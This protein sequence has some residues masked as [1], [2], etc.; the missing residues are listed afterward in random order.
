MEN[1]HGRVQRQM[2]TPR[3]EP[4]WVSRQNRDHDI[5]MQPVIGPQQ[6]FEQPL[7]HEA[8]SAGQKQAR[9]GERRPALTRLLKH[10]IEILVGQPLHIYLTTKGDATKL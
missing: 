8:G 6:A 5:Q 3:S 4:F 10:V 9:L 7:P 1:V 2:R